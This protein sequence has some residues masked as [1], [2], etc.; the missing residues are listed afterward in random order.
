[1]NASPSFRDIAQR[2]T[3]P[4]LQR[5]YRNH[6]RW[7][8][9]LW[10]ILELSAVK[11]AF[12]AKVEEPVLDLG[13][14]D[15]HVFEL[16]FGSTVDATGIDMSEVAVDAAR[17]GKVYRRAVAGDARKMEFRSGEFRTVFS[18]S[19][20]EHI[21][22]VD[23]VLVETRR[24][25]QPGG[26][27]IFTTPSPMI[28]SRGSYFWLK[29]LSPFGLERVGQK[30][31][32]REDRI[33]HHVSIRSAD[34]WTAALKRANFSAVKATEYVPT[35]AALPISKLSG[36]S[37][38]QG[39]PTLLGKVLRDPLFQK[40]QVGLSEKEWVSF[41][42]QKLSPYVQECAPGQAGCGLL[43]VATA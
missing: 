23:E 42:S 31:A 32:N 18:N 1:M 3:E 19:V 17:R 5:A 7:D 43:I 14:G 25:L 29:T 28:R 20:L 10:R 34:E 22:A 26:M 21:D 9:G 8:E 38:I 39:L 11:L 2:F 41:Y 4:L 40:Y 15:G 35:T 36:A 37:R 13:C 16:L 27:F 33:Y 6:E 24:V 12:Q 30:I